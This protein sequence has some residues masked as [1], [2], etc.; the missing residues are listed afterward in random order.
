MPCVPVTGVDD[1]RCDPG[2]VSETFVVELEL[3][4]PDL[5]MRVEAV[6]LDERNRGEH[7]REVRLEPG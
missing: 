2:E 1:E 6:E 4:S 5:G 3:T 7:I